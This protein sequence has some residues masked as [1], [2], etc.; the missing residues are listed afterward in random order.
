MSAGGMWR[1]GVVFKVSRRKICLAV[2]VSSMC[3]MTSLVRAIELGH[4][5][6]CRELPPASELPPL[7]CYYLTMRVNQGRSAVQVEGFTGPK[8]LR[9]K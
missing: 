6:L 2:F 7:I 4:G 1:F 9:V 8:A 5:E 3:R